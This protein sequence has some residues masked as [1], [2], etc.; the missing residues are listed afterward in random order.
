[1]ERAHIVLPPTSPEDDELRWDRTTA[2]DGPTC[3]RFATK[4]RKTVDNVDEIA[5]LYCLTDMVD[6]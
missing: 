2:G 4:F 1:M 6:G 5:V 3:E